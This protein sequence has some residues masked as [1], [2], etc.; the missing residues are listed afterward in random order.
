MDFLNAHQPDLIFNT[1]AQYI[2]DGVGGDVI[3]IF[4]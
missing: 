4:N 2:M 1:M 3:S